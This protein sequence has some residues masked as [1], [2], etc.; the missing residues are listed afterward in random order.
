ML[1]RKAF[2]FSPVR[3]FNGRWRVDRLQGW[4]MLLSWAGFGAASWALVIGLGMAIWVA[5]M[6]LMWAFR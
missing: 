3:T 4:R 1:D 5:F 6:A 2:E